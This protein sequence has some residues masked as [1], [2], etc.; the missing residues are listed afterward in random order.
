MAIH[1]VTGNTAQ[2]KIGGV[3]RKGD[4]KQTVPSKKGGVETRVG[5]DLN[6]FRFTGKGSESHVRR[7][8]SVFREVYGNQPTE[9][10]CWLFY[11]QAT[12]NLDA[13]MVLYSNSANSKRKNG[14]LKVK[15]DRVNQQQWWDGKRYRFDPKPC[16]FDPETGKCSQGCRQAAKLYFWIPELFRAGFADPIQLVTTSLNDIAGIDATLRYWESL[17]GDIRGV[18]F[19]LERAP[20]LINRPGFDKGGNS[21]EARG[22]MESWLINLKPHPGWV[23]RQLAS[24]YEQQMGLEPSRPVAALPAAQPVVTVSAETVQ[25]SHNVVDAEMVDSEPTHPTLHPRLDALCS[26]TGCTVDVLQAI[27]RN[28]FSKSLATLSEAEISKLRSM[29]F[30]QYC[31][32]QLFCDSVRATAL[33]KEFWSDASYGDRKTQSDLEL[34]NQWRGFVNAKALEV[35]LP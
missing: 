13:W 17:T 20:E 34:W 27:A 25:H 19:V 2:L 11:S 31:E 5:R 26:M 10:N 1:G 24:N 21:V 9:I 22:E 12:A 14:W 23:Q 35:S 18:P 33:F 29:V 3:L 30:I 8:E 16:E 4:A 32:M 6:Y 7:I 28:T 15:C